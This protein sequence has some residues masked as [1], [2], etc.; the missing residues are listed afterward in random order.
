MPKILFFAVIILF[1]FNGCSDKHENADD[2]IK[3]LISAYKQTNNLKYRAKLSQKFF[4]D[5]DTI[6]LSADVSLVK[7]KTDT[8]YGGSIDLNIGDSIRKI[9]CRDTI[10]EIRSNDKKMI[11]YSA[12]GN[13]WVI[14]G[15][16]SRGMIN[17]Y[18]LKPTLLEEIVK[19]RKLEKQRS[20]VKVG[21]E[22]AVKISI[23]YPSTPQ[24]KV[25]KLNFFLNE[26]EDRLLKIDET[27]EFQGNFQFSSCEFSEVDANQKINH[28]Q[29]VDNLR[30]NYKPEIY[31]KPT[32]DY[33]KLLS[34]GSVAPNFTA[35][36]ALT[37][38]PFELKN[39]QKGIIILDFSYMA[40]MPCI[41]TIKELNKIV[42]AYSGSKKLTIV[43]VNS[44]DKN[45]SKEQI[46]KFR[47]KNSM[48]YPMLLTEKSTD[49]IYLVKVYPTLYIIIDGK[50]EAAQMGHINGLAV[51]LDTFLKKRMK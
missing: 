48:L 11:L 30:K 20:E 42:S 33:Y 9:Y 10:F 15:N 7:S 16:V 5:N 24:N 21:E 39:Y 14:D 51:N 26:N 40:C 49:E 1:I 3:N 18:F 38:E 25:H 6:T 50:I 46:K 2:V 32:D 44:K 22:N 27:I 41:E 36:D 28:A 31:Q 8:L 17:D 4:S 35:H 13:E 37:N 12:A 19:N 47:E 45:K 23:K 43:A 29:I 34:N